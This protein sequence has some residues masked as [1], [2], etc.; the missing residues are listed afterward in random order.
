MANEADTE[1]SSKIPLAAVLS[2]PRRG[3]ICGGHEQ[4]IT[5]HLR[6]LVDAERRA[7]SR[8][9]EKDLT[10]AALF[11]ASDRSR[12]A[13]GAREGEGQVVDVH[14]LEMASE[15]TLFGDAL[16]EV[17]RE[18]LWRH[19]ELGVR[20]AGLI[21]EGGERR[22]CT[23]VRRHPSAEVWREPL[24]HGSHRS[25]RSPAFKNP[26][27]DPDRVNSFPFRDSAAGDRHS[28]RTVCDGR[29]E[30]CLRTWAASRPSAEV[31]MARMGEERSVR[32][33]VFV[34]ATLVV[35]SCAQPN[36]G[37]EEPP[38]D[39]PTPRR[40]RGDEGTS[41]ILGDPVPADLEPPPTPCTDA[42]NAVGAKRCS[43][44]GNTGTEIC[45]R[46]PEGCL[47]WTQGPDCE[48]GS[49]CDMAKNDGSCRAG[50][51][52]DPGCDASREGTTQCAPTGTAEQI[53]SKVGACWVFKTGRTGIPQQCKSGVSCA[54]NAR[55]VCTASPAGACTQH[56]LS[57]QPCPAGTVCQGAGQCVATCTNACVENTSVCA[58]NAVFTCKRGANG[59]TSYVTT[60]S[61]G[62]K[63]A[64]CVKLA[65]PPVAVCK[66]CNST[67]AIA[68]SFACTSTT[69]YQFCR[70]EPNGCRTLVLGSCSAPVSG[71]P[72]CF[73]QGKV[74]CGAK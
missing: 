30:A 38:S 58:N 34:V 31:T 37:E 26:V 46:G 53:C 17:A 1:P 43:A 44:S 51:T 20:R 7:N 11:E 2:D 19:R 48:A 73:A 33:K 28:A 49:T 64:T 18:G 61:C 29:P 68:N 42:C 40:S 6:D 3:A 60:D 24:E 56:V 52:N 23:R 8:V 16:D 25:A 36:F 27:T 65:S 71:P 15:I 32:A 63:D 45:G 50:C 69:N 21:D 74:G 5:H 22:R 55:Q 4:A 10:E 12:V 35:A 67:C 39:A 54:G 62:A 13:G 66:A 41:E 59:C 72:N 47:A 14:G 9:G 57:T 70:Q